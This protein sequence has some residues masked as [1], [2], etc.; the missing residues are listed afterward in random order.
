ML[1]PIDTVTDLVSRA[2]S[3]LRRAAL[4]SMHTLEAAESNTL[5]RLT[6]E[7]ATF[8]EA[9][10]LVRFATAEERERERVMPA[11]DAI[12]FDTW[13]GMPRRRLTD[14]RQAVVAPLTYGRGRICVGAWDDCGYRDG[15]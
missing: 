4:A 2:E 7:L 5:F 6:E 14:G 13:Q 10:G 8:R 9:A 15:Y 3:D 12:D 11:N 1:A